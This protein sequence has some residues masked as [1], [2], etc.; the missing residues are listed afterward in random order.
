MKLAR[1]QFF[2]FNKHGGV[3][4]ARDVE[5]GAGDALHA[6]DAVFIKFRCGR[7]VG[8]VI[9]LGPIRMREPFVG[10]VLRVRGYGV[11]EALHGFAD[12]VGHG[13]VDLISRVISFDGKPA[14]LDVRWV[15]SDGLI[16]LEGVEEVGGVV[17]GK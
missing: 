12:G 13:D 5:E 9:H 8:R 16:L 1:R 11:L 2:E 4:G 6:H 10:R 15:D 3:N 7:G 17:G 14:V